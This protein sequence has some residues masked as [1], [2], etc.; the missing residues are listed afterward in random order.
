LQF[1]ETTT[2]HLQQ[3][4]VVHYYSIDFYP[5]QNP[6]KPSI[7]WF[8]IF[9]DISTYKKTEEAFLASENKIDLCFIPLRCGLILDKD[10][11]YLE[12]HDKSGKPAEIH[13]N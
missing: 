7:G 2:V 11:R 6:P 5:I 13:C 8:A 4:G 1:A 12:T 9:H 10:G 3:N